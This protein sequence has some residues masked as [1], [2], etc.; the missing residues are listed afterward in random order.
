MDTRIRY[1]LPAT[2]RLKSRKQIGQLFAAGQQFSH[3]PFRVY[4]L[5]A[6]EQQHLQVGVGVSNRLFKRAVDRNRI[7]RLMREAWRLNKQVLDEQLM[8]N[9][10]RL[11]VFILYTGKELP[12]FQETEQKLK[13]IIERLIKRTNEAA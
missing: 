9:G 3:F 7:K 13:G 11:S 6:N 10:K 2:E 12:V 4:Y 1:K 8:A 5:P